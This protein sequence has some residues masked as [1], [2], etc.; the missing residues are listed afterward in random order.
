MKTIDFERKS[1]VLL[2]ISSLPS[3]YG[4]GTFGKEAYEFVDFL[5]VSKQSLWQI[6]PIGPTGYG[7]SPYQS[8]SAFAGNPY[9]I[10]LDML[11]DEKLLEKA[12]LETLKTPKNNSY[13][14]YNFLWETR[15]IL[16]KK[17]FE[18]FT[19]NAEF[20][21]FKKE[22]LWLDDYTLYMSIKGKF[23]NKEWLLWDEDIRKFSE[24]A[25]LKYK[26]I[27]EDDMK[28]W[29]F[30]QFK[31]YEQWFKLKKYANENG[32]KIIGD[33]PIYVAMD[34][35][36]TWA[37]YTQFLLDENHKPTV[38]AGVAPDYFSEDGQLWGN[39]IYDWN[40]MKK[41]DFSWWKNRISFNA[42]LYDYIRIDHFIGI[43]RYYK[44][45]YGSKDGKI[46][47]FCEGPNYDFIEAIE[48][49]AGNCQIIAEDLGI[50]TNEV[51]ELIA[52]S[53]YPGMKVLQFAFDQNPKNDHLPC[54]YNRNSC[55][56]LGTHDNETF[57]ATLKNM[58]KNQ[59]KQMTEYI[60]KKC[61]KVTGYDFIKLAFSSTSKIA[62][63][64]MQDL[65]ELGNEARMNF[66]STV[67][68]NWKWRVTKKQI[69]P[70]LEKKLAKLSETYNRNLFEKDE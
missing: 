16:L 31:F 55:V 11:V 5:K 50:I 61:F 9:F 59:R 60:G 34:S 70:K 37:N 1:G 48:E 22:N 43:S 36:D 40:F 56:Y 66:P 28:F 57:C 49:V 2:H 47:E 67:G 26:K 17:A 18:N 44:I 52:K 46:G 24:E 7:D 6:L 10:D 4:I 15:Y 54:N 62:I 13:V 20:E 19:E 68:N 21:L 25:V 63:I 51:R 14:E 64:Q 27:C 32:V 45:P 69:S 41:D 8:F 58:S 12:D 38:V 23:D 53:G 42:L 39:A 33:I 3:A 65:L 35:A 29:A 30:L